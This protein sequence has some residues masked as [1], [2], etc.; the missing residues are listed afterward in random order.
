MKDK[1][2][3]LIININ[4]HHVSE[5]TAQISYY[6]ILSFVPFII[7]LMTLI[8][9]IGIDES[10]L[11]LILEEIIPSTMNKD[12]IN[13]VQEIYSK[14]IGTISVSLIFTLWSAGRG[15]YSLCEGFDEIYENN[16][17]KKSYIYNKIRSIIF[18]I[19]FLLIIVIILILLPFGNKIQ[20]MINIKFNTISKITNII[21]K[22]RELIL[23]ICMFSIFLMVYQFSLRRE[24]KIRYQL[25]GIII[26]TIG[27]T[28]ISYI[29]S[30]YLTL[31]SG[32]SETYGS[33]TTIILLMM[34]VYLCI[35]IILVALEINKML[36]RNKK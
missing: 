24:I 8:K 14:S 13:I 36:V 35:Y 28:I 31:F 3:D 6:I 7:L 2:K 32:F 17:K 19:I 9:Y 10:T 22:S 29:F 23:F 12:V 18:T 11:I 34:W 20:N 27:W 26:S 33:L 25:P 15:F 4:N 16:D 1:I 30:I 21:L 5:H